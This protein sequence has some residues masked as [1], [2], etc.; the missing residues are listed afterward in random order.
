MDIQLYDL[1]D[2]DV[3]DITVTTSEGIF[4]IREVLDLESINPNE[5]QGCPSHHACPYEIFIEYD[6]L[7]DA[8]SENC[9]NTLIVYGCTEYSALNFNEI[10]NVDDGTCEHIYGCN[11]SLASNYNYEA[12]SIDESCI[13][14]GCT[15]ELAGNFDQLANTDDGSCLVGG[16]LN[17]TAENYNSEAQIDDGSCI[18]FGCTIDLFPN[19]NPIANTGNNSCDMS[20]SDIFG[21]TGDSMLNFNE[22]AN[23]DNGTCSN[24][25][26]I[27]DE[28]LGGIVFYIDSTGE[29]G[30]IVSKENLSNN[31]NNSWTSE[32]S[33]LPH[34]LAKEYSVG[35]GLGNTISIESS[36]SFA[37]ACLSY[38]VDGFDDWFLPS[39]NELE[40]IFENL[41]PLSNLFNTY[42]FNNGQYYSSTIGD[43]NNG[44]GLYICS[45][46]N[47]C[48]PSFSIQSSTSGYFQ[49]D[50][51]SVRPI[52]AFGDW[53]LGC[54]DFQA[55][56]YNPQA[57]MSDGSCEYTE[58]GYDCE[59][60]FIEYVIGM[61]AQGGIVFYIDETGEH[62]LVANIE[63]LG[64]FEWGCYHENADGAD[65]ESI[66]SGLSEHYRYC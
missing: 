33:Y 51:A 46:Y 31:G 29:K 18:I 43:Y 56:N 5:I 65:G 47:D 27:G 2:G 20:S 32:N 21:C 52:K 58:L 39:I 8:F 16:C 6:S 48:C 23:I 25:A 19:F 1:Y 64:Q 57:N 22:Y 59:G 13:Y 4:T 44:L 45:Y 15:D 7:A 41:Q 3:I 66:G 53:I 24:I 26:A 14:Y 60:N 61:E 34:S 50:F 42:F 63:D 49:S 36:V 28:I 40:K 37:S 11:D 12:T 38:D 62:G 9:C 17:I 30:L 54:T 10:A 55:C 35:S